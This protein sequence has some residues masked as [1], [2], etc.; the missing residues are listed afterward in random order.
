[1]TLTP[2]DK[3]ALFAGIGVSFLTWM[4]L[5]K[6]DSLAKL[7]HVTRWVS[8]ERFFKKINDNKGVSILI[9]EVINYTVH[10]ISS[11]DSV[12]FAIGSTIVN[13]LFI[14]VVLPVKLAKWKQD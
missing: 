3:G 11:P 8:Q 13:A 2:T 9:T 14:F 4:S 1:M 5:F 6:L 10:G 12:I 7:L